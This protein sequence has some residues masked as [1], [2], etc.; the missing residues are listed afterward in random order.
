MSFRDDETHL[1]DIVRSIAL[2]EDFIGGMS[3]EIYE[4]DLKTKS[5]VERQLQVITE[6]AYRLGDHAEEVCPGP[7]WKG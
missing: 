3:F 1:R 4:Q 2:I 5:A 6:A 7:D